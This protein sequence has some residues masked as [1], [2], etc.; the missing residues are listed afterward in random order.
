MF[1]QKDPTHSGLRVIFECEF[2]VLFLTESFYF[3][4][5]V[6]MAKYGFCFILVQGALSTLLRF[7]ESLFLFFLFMSYTM[8]VTAKLFC[9]DIGSLYSF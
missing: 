5:D 6:W 4:K 7:P 1:R 8:R 9:N 2:G 3:V